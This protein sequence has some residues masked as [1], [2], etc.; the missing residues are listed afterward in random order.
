M[1]NLRASTLRFLFVTP[2]FL[3]KMDTIAKVLIASSAQSL[4]RLFDYAAPDSM[5][6]FLQIG[7]RVIVPFQNRLQ[8]GYIWEI[9]TDTAFENLKEIKELLDKPSLLSPI[10]YQ[11]VNWLADYYFC[12]RADVVR[13][14][15][16]PGQKKLRDRRGAHP[17]S[18]HAK[19]IKLYQWCAGSGGNENSC[20]SR[21]K[22]VL[23]ET[24]AGMGKAEL[25]AA[26]AVSASVVER[27]VRQNKIRTV[28][29]QENRRPIGFEEQ[30][31]VN[32]RVTLNP[33]QQEIY[34]AI[35]APAPSP[36]LLHGVTGSG[37]TEVYFETAA[38][39]LDQGKQVLYLVPEIALTPQ[40]LERARRR[41]GDHVALLHSN[42]SDGERYDEWWR[43][44]NG[45]AGFVLG[46][47][48]AIFAPF[49]RLGLII[50]DE[51]HENTYK[52]EETPRYHTHHVA[53]K[54]AELTGAVLILGS[55]TPAVESYFYGEKQHYSL[56]HLN[57]RFNMQPLPQVQIVDMRQELQSGNRNILSGPL[58]EAIAENI[59]NHEQV[60]L[61]L[62]RR[63]YAT[64]VLCRDCGQALKCPS[65][66]VSLTYH[67]SETVLRCHYCDFRSP[68]PDVCPH[69]R[70]S[71]I[72]YFGHGTQRLEEELSTGFPGVRLVRMDVDTTARKGAHHQI[73]Q[74]L[75][76][77]AIDILLGTQMIAK[78]L[79]LPE[80][81]LVG[82]ISADATL[83]IPDFRAAERTFQLLT[84][85]AGRAGRGRKPG[86]V[87]FQAYN[88]GHYS[89]HFAQNHDYRG[90]YQKE[91]EQREQLKYPP[92]SELLRIGFSGLRA[93][94]VE[95]A[96]LLWG[97]MSREKAAHA[98]ESL[99]NPDAAPDFLEILGPS[100]CLIPRLQNR[101]RWQMLFKS[102]QPQWLEAIV[103][104]LWA[105][106]PFQKFR[107]VRFVKDRHPYSIV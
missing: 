52:Q 99:F 102:N 87:I 48:S 5:R 39:L 15:M 2:V 96:A 93:D 51:E 10:H 97:K 34:H 21:V 14:C 90:F 3:M 6:P 24:P 4:D 104:A 40:M 95:A 70:S 69:C 68:V 66:D 50:I 38:R 41:F 13:L 92:F 29:Y 45:A 32:R 30:S 67:Q 19:F 75:R 12:G 20:G 18:Q 80:I 100:P 58:R 44:K 76:D 91:I 107:E 83:N 56:L 63:G 23:L 77:G 7:A 9:T 61:L 86:R 35:S 105:D 106:F 57:S 43:V 103:K 47:R 89:L 73:Y 84:Q 59:A 25:C 49:D 36:F 101:Y 1:F 85:V 53:R 11:L 46:A 88:S 8:L 74:Q 27:L 22:N 28:S 81:T 71:R 79:D 37:K 72:R 17:F 62:N 94:Q 16:P 42:M 54:L 60:L 78:G 64:F 31:D 55:A 65:C 82:V 26:A 98:R 33:E